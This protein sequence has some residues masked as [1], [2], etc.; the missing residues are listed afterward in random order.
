MTKFHEFCHSLPMRQ[1]PGL[2]SFALVQVA[3]DQ[4]NALVNKEKLAQP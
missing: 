2:K 4:V 1:M 3:I